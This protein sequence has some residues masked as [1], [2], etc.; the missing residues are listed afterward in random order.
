M[1]KKKE[2]RLEDIPGIGEKTAQ[3]LREVGY[4]DPMAIA[5]ASPTELAAIAE[6]GEGQAA[7]IINSVREMLEIGYESADKIL[8]RRL[9]VAKI[10]T[11][12]KNLDNLLGG[13]IET[14]AITESYGQFGC[15][16]GDSK[17]N[18]ADGRVL[19]ISST[20]RTLSPGI[21]PINLPVMTMNGSIKPA[22]ATKLY[23]YECDKVLQISLE[24]GSR[25]S[26]TPN[27]PLL[28][29]DGWLEAEK[30]KIND[31][32]MVAHDTSFSE[33]YVKLDT[34]IKFYNNNPY[35][36]LAKPKLPKILS[37]DLAE[38]IGYIL[39]KGWFETQSSC[40]SF[41]RV[42]IGNTNNSVIKRFD[43]L[44]QKIFDINTDHSRDE[45]GIRKSD[46]NSVI[47]GEFLRQ[48]DGLYYEA[49]EKFVP[50]QIFESPKDVIVKFLAA[51]FDVEGRVTFDMFD[52][53]GIR[54]R[55]CVDRI[56]TYEYTLPNYSGSINLK[57]SSRKIL[58]DIKL[59]LSKFSIK[60]WISSDIK[61]IDD[62]KFVGFDLHIK[63][64]NS[65]VI[66]YKEI[67]QYTTSLSEKIKML[68]DC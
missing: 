13:G 65:I 27:H 61:R 11:G 53:R 47:V 41:S 46:I 4:T 66:F 67:G 37:P 17:I 64:K 57:S 54:L 36:K 15:I 10:T 62:K 24:D 8:E 9:K 30:L 3:K 58:E 34:K 29:F 1:N 23:I 51:F 33:R 55:K 42:S 5:V 56:K 19:P 52:R 63:D 68:I 2:I 44:V 50:N 18:L 49:R 22:I 26:V 32:I 39:A 28:T 6:I 48:F 59:L 45:K 38:L 21:Y 14:Q 35:E 20:A 60:S 7:K 43:Y 12:S 31:S 16:T 25:L 40:N